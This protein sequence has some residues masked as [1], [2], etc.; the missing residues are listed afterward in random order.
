TFTATLKTASGTAGGA[1]IGVTDSGTASFTG[2]QADIV[3]RP[4]AAA[5]FRVGGFPSPFSAGYSANFTVT[6]SDA[7]R[8]VAT[9]YTGKV[10]FTSSDA[11]AGLP[12]DYTFTASD[13][14]VHTFSAALRT[15]GDQSI[16]ATDTANPG[17]T[18]SQTGIRVIPVATITGPSAGALGQALT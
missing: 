2:F 9:G 12:A 7:Y 8:N 17:L 18:G 4:A 13:G 3:V 15:A 6:A 10:H 14:G 11:Q 1:W 16:T 5:T